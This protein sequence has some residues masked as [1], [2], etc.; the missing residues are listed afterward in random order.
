MRWGTEPGRLTQTASE[1]GKDVVY[2]YSYTEEAG[3][4]TYQ[5]RRQWWSGRRASLA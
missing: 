2:T 4:M 5:V 1:G 3:G